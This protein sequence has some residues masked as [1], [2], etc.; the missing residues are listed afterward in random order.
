MRIGF[1]HNRDDLYCATRMMYFVNKGHKVIAIDVTELVNVMNKVE[2]MNEL[3]TFFTDS[4]L[5]KLKN[6]PS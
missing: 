2:S 5:E 4:P 1:L 6:E 3:I